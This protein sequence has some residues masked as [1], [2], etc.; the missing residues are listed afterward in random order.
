M[1]GGHDGTWVGLIELVARVADVHNPVAVLPPML[2]PLAERAESLRLPTP[3]AAEGILLM[4]LNWSYSSRKAR[5]ELGYRTRPL[6]ATVQQTV[7]WYRE[8]IDAGAMSGGVSPLS[9]GAA[10]MRLAGHAGL[11]ALARAA[12]RR[13][14]RKLVAGG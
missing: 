6:E 11:T 14:G 2:G 5:G 7:D 8:L 4:G 13:A 9:L 10:G 12:G 1:L 3:I